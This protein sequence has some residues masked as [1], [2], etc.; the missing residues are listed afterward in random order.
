LKVL[1]VAIG[2]PAR[3][4]DAVAWRVA[5]AVADDEPA[6]AV[7][8]SEGLRP[9]LAARLADAGGVIF[10][11]ARDAGEPGTVTVERLFPATAEGDA[12]AAMSPADLLALVERRHG[13][14]PRAALVTVS[15]A[16][17]ELGEGLSEPVADAVPTATRCVLRLADDWAAEAG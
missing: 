4:D 17:F 11:D 16:R 12:A 1:V 6:L 3:E 2:N 15:G 13:H 14:A 9:D 5:E 8:R 7:V 10:V